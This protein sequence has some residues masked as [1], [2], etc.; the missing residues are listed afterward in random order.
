VETL[1]E[2]ERLI[3][4]AL[5]AHRLS[6]PDYAA[7]AAREFNYVTPEN[8][9]KWDATEPAQGEFD[10]ALAE[11]IMEFAEEHDQVVKG[12][13]LVWFRQLPAW[14][15]SLSGADALRTAM[16]DHVRT[17][18]EHFQ[19]R[20]LSWDVVNE[21]LDPNTDDGFRNDVFFTTLGESYIDDAFVAAREADPDALLFYNDFGIEG[22]GR[23]SDLAFNL[24]RRLVEDGVPIDGVGLQMHVRADSGPSADDV[25]FNIARY[26][27]LGVT[28]HISEMDVNVCRVAGTPDEKFQAQ[29]RRYQEI[30]DVCV[31][32]DACHG[33]TLWGVTDQYS[34]LN[35]QSPCSEE[36]GETGEPWPLAFDDGYQKK[37]AWS[38][39]AAALLGSID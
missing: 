23:K 13:A 16:L 5:A 1:R 31:D 7:V 10:F 26:A 8:E 14:V 17:V 29:R 25:A 33:V 6:E 20:V 19:G 15:Q 37:P 9:M 22:R 3:G 4:A 2:T 35:G 28:V 12:H 38:G 30:I 18:A 27:S 24:V 11:A 32:S 34:W 39:I 36:E 21:A